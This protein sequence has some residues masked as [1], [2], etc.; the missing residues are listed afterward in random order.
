MG[1]LVPKTKENAFCDNISQYPV[2]AVDQVKNKIRTAY[3]PE[4]TFA[5]IF[6]GG[7]SNDRKDPITIVKNLNE[8]DVIDNIGVP[9]QSE[10]SQLLPHRNEH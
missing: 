9:D 6:F 2:S 8:T 3:G 4:Q 7:L 10:T 1:N 5:F